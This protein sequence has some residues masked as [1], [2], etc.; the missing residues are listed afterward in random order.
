MASATNILPVQMGT[1]VICMQKKL[2]ISTWS[3]L[4]MRPI[5][6][7]VSPMGH[8]ISSSMQSIYRSCKMKSYDIDGFVESLIF[9]R[10]ARLAGLQRIAIHR[11]EDV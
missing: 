11:D 10:G 4:W 7:R 8:L 2:I 1:Y 5:P 6:L 9:V 3:K